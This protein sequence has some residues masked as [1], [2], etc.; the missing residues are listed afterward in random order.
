MRRREF[1]HLA[2]NAA[3][4]ARSSRLAFAAPA[5]FCELPAPPATPILPQPIVQLNRTRVDN[6]AW[7]KD[8]HWKEVWRDPFTL[9]PQ[10]QQHLDAENSYCD[11]VLGPTVPLQKQLYREMSAR[12]ATDQSPP[13]APDG[14][15]IYWSSFAPGAQHPFWYRRRRDGQGSEELLL[16]GDARAQGRASFNIVSAIPSPDQKLFAWAEDAYG[17]EKFSICVKDLETGEILPHPAQSAFG[18]FVFSPDSQWIF[19]VWRDENSRPAKI[20]RRPVRGS[21]DAL[22]FHETDPAFLMTVSCTAAKSYIM[23]RSW[24]AQSSEVQLI[25]G[26]APTELPRVFEPRG[27][28]LLYSVEDWNGRFVVLT[29]AD[30]AVNF[31]LMWADKGNT[32]RQHWRDWIPY[33]PGHYILGMQPF[34]RYF[35]RTER[36]DANPRLT[37]TDAAT[38]AEYEISF[39]EPAFSVTLSDDQEYASSTLRFSY[40]S[41]RQPVQWIA[42][43][44]ATRERTIEKE[45]SAG[46][47]FDR[48]NYLVERL[49]ARAEDGALVPMTV[50]R[51]RDTPINGKAPLMMYGY[52]AYGYFVPPDFSAPNLSLVDRGWIYAIAHVRGGSAKGWSWFLEA[53]RLHKKLSFTDFISCA[54]SLIDRRYGRAGKIVIY[55]FSAGGLLAGAVNNM[56]PDLWAGVIGQAPFVD[57]LN[58]MSDASHPLVPLTRP[59]WGNPL[60]DP[61][62]YD[63]IASYSPY[64]NV[65][66]QAYPPVLAT[67][68]VAD[69]RVGYWEPAKWIAKLRACDTSRNPK[70]LHVEMEGGHGGAAG[71]LSELQQ[72]ALLYAFAI[73]AVK[74][75]CHRGSGA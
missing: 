22:V 55:G 51:R 73:W 64:D 26:A 71:R 36:V 30:G 58:T 24:N 13:P 63:Y 31:K 38:L 66:H 44:L 65:R 32:S 5:D 19:W 14:E 12:T 75:D 68:S 4:L 35:V 52:G 2:I 57:M 34:Q 33:H 25:S 54:T 60:A 59:D 8:P 27:P 56:R 10:I 29:N 70:L 72:T 41:P 21:D 23:I 1:L 62:A 67:T 28:G 40:Q 39:G 17:G 69:D 46:P 47:G 18:P 49:F 42:C 15:W 74:R 50:L 9:N 61:Q 6:Y 48:N 7:L 37:V 53:R 16:D 45:Q 11:E 3:I 43:D 20:F